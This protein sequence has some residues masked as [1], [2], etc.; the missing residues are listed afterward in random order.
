MVTKYNKDW[1]FVPKTKRK[2]GRINIVDDSME[3]PLQGTGV[4]QVAVLKQQSR[5]LCCMCTYDVCPVQEAC[6]P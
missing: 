4:N 5:K 6:L 1:L 3:A 2:N